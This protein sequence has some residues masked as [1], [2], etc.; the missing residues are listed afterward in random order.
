[1]GATGYTGVPTI[2]AFTLVC[3]WNTSFK[4]FTIFLLTETVFALASF[5]MLIFFNFIFKCKNISFQYISYC[6]S[7][8]FFKVIVII[9]HV[10]ITF[11]KLFTLACWS[12]GCLIS[13]TLTIELKTFS[14]FTFATHAL[15]YSRFLCFYFLK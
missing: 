7:S 4:A 11:R 15:L 6:V 8:L 14:I 9:T 10:I 3:A 13:K 1:M 5:K 12:T 2:F